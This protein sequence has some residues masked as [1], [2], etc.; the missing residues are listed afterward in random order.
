MHDLEMLAEIADG[1]RMKRG[2]LV[3]VGSAGDHGKPGP[4]LVVQTDL[5]AEHPSVTICR[6]TTHLQQ[7]PLFR[8]M[9]EPCPENGLAAPSQVQIDKIMAIPR[10]KV[11]Q[12]IGTLT[13][14]QMRYQAA[15]ALGRDCRLTLYRT[16]GVSNMK[17]SLS[18]SG[19]RSPATLRLRNLPPEEQGPFWAWLTI[20][21]QTRPVMAGI[22][23]QD[24]DFCYAHDY[25][26]WKSGSRGDLV[27][28]ITAENLQKPQRVLGLMSGKASFSTPRGFKISD[29]D[30]LSS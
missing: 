28:R 23:D 12:T 10:Q 9:V 18:K 11:G 29:D 15:H 5:F 20:N 13:G 2:D 24:Q 6:L 3:L 8:H 27:S 4:A 25:E 16:Q 1:V 22:P 17:A 19:R 14:K 26:D 30:L 7:T 21:G